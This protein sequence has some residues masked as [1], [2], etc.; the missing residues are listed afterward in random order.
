MDA[1][2]EHLLGGEVAR[3]VERV[4]EAARLVDISRR[5][6]AR[7]ASSLKLSS[8]SVVRSGSIAASSTCGRGRDHLGEARRA[9]QHVAEQ[10]AHLVVGAQN[11]QQLDRGVHPRHAPRRRRRARRRGRRS[12]R[13]PR[14][15]PAS[16]PSAPRG[17]GRSAPPPGGRNASRGSSRPPPPDAGSRDGA[18][19]ASVSGSS[20]TPVKTR[21]PAATLERRGVLEQ[22]RVMLLDP[23]QMEGQVLRE[24]FEP[25][26]AAEP[27]EAG[28]RRRARTAGAASARRRS[29][30]AGAR[31]GAGR[32]RRR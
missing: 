3:A 12:R 16:A 8:K 21:L 30:A 11:R 19:V 1:D 28:E 24:R 26:I 22:P 5:R 17:R 14:A 9:A 32:D 10:F 13:R 29:S 6:A 20:A 15:A 23:R 27:G 7:V 4:L 2:Q 18:S 25:R 31:P